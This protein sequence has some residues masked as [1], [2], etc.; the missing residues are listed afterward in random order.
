MISNNKT[1]LY[2]ITR[3]DLDGVGG[4]LYFFFSI[5]QTISTVYIYFLF[6][7]S[8]NFCRNVTTLR[9]RMDDEKTKT[10]K[11]FFIT[12]LSR[13]LCRVQQKSQTPMSSLLE[14]IRALPVD[15]C[16]MFFGHAVLSQIFYRVTRLSLS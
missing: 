12:F 1:R 14:V 11:I 4:K 2:R 8:I 3:L 10:R 6:L 7:I 15:V 13:F 9:A 16:A 5:E